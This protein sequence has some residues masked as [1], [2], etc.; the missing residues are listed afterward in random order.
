MRYNRLDGFTHVCFDKEYSG[1]AYDLWFDSLGSR[2]KKR[3]RPIMVYA[4][5]DKISMDM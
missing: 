5:V 1:L 4:R 3:N 2:R